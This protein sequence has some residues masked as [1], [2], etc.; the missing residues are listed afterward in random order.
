MANNDVAEV[1]ITPANT[2]PPEFLIHE[3]EET[4]LLLENKLDKCKTLVEDKQEMA[5]Q[6]QALYDE[7][8]TNYHMFD[9]KLEKDML[10]MKQQ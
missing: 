4:F 3:G 10:H 2:I 1:T 7:V 8:E 6:G 9:L 5:I